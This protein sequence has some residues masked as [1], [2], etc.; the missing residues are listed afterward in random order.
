MK[1]LERSPEF[2]A[3]EAIFRQNGIIRGQYTER[4]V[5]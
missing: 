2:L 5:S 1:A 3:L 4:G